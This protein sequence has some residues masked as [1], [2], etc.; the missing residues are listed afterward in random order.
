[1][2]ALDLDMGFTVFGVIL[3]GG[4]LYLLPTLIGLT[5]E[6][7]DIGSVVVINLLLGWTLIGWVVALAMAARTIRDPAVSG[8]APPAPTVPAAWYPDPFGR[9]EQRWHDGKAWTEHV[10]SDRTQGT[11]PPRPM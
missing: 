3:F 8:W 4:T 11:D 6:V 2:L 9:F 1:M 5:R 7:P 10:V